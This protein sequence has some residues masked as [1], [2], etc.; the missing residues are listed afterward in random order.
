MRSKAQF[1][2]HPI[3]PMM[4]AFPVAFLYGAAIIDVVGAISG[5]RQTWVV[6]AYLSVAAV[7]TGLAAGI[8]GL[9]D[10]LYVIPPRSSAKRRATWHMAVNV[11][12]LGLMA[13]SWPFRNW[14]TFQPSA[15]TIALEVAALLLVTWGG[16]LGGT[17]VYRNQIGVDHR[18]AQAGKWRELSVEAKNTG[19]I[20]VAE[21][22][23][24]KIGQ[25]LLVH[26]GQRRIVLAR[27]ERGYAAFDDRCT[28]RGGSLADGVLA[29]EQVCCPWHGSQFNVHNGS[30]QAGPAEEAI[31]TY[32][33][34]DSGGDVRII[35]PA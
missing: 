22:R 34:D 31:R 30:V 35:I 21:A 28:H 13:L 15:T 9:I 6:G 8:P 14:E 16:W 27:T 1:K 19:P 23:S 33:I 3:H 32:Q 11:T 24:L 7:V 25:M 18:Y 17:L 5:W 4:V 10:Y 26:A 2:S 29:C 20:A 12:A